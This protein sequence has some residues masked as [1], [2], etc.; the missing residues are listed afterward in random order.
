MRRQ[1]VKYSG[2]LQAVSSIARA[3]EC[4]ITPSA[5]EKTASAG[6]SPLGESSD[7]LRF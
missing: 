4:A 3:K 5:R 2:H 1:F 7:R 6:A